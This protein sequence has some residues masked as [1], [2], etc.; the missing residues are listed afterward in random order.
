MTVE[1]TGA[2]GQ[3]IQF[4]Q[5]TSINNLATKTITMWAYINTIG[6]VDV[7]IDKYT[8]DTGW[9][10]DENTATTGGIGKIRYGQHF[11]DVFWFYLAFKVVN[12]S[13]RNF[14]K[15]IAQFLG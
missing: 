9:L 1:F 8:S 2:S 11:D 12:P 5:S 13:N 15:L 14:L 7:L 3:G 10:I 4:P 6:S